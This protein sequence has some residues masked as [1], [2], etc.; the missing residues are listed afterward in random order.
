MTI[1]ILTPAQVMAGLPTLRKSAVELEANIHQ[2]GVS[3]LDHV[4]DT[5]D[6]RGVTAL[7]NALP[8]SQRVQALAE[9][10]R[11]FSSGALAL[12]LKEGVWSAQLRGDVA[13]R[14]V[15]FRIADAMLTT[16]ADFTKEVAAKPLTMAKFIANIARVANN[17]TTLPNGARKVPEEVAVVASDMLRSIRA[18]Q[19]A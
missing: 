2:Y 7:L 16:Y 12:T 14:D 10:Y 18:K 19:A 11:E 6:Y 15:D 13:N 17:T 5:G 1:A 8:K 4:R 3:T 9:W